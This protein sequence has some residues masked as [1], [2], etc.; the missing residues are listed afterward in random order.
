MARTESLQNGLAFKATTLVNHSLYSLEQNEAPAVIL[1]D[2][3]LVNNLITG[4]LI[5]KALSVLID[6]K[7]LPRFCTACQP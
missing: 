1:F 5:S 7:T 4:G 6:E 2:Q 3:V